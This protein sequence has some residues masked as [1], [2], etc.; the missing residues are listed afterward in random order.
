MQ[1]EFQD[2]W[3][4]EGLLSGKGERKQAW[5]I[6]KKFYEEKSMQQVNIKK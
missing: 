6:M 3:N 5:Y 2:G 1:P 4:R